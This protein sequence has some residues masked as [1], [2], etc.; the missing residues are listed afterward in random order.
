M[1]LLMQNRGQTAAPAIAADGK[2]MLATAAT[3]LICPQTL[4]SQWQAE[5]ERHSAPPMSV[6]VYT[7]N[8]RGI[9]LRQIAA[10]DVVLVSFEA[11]KGEFWSRKPARKSSRYVCGY[12]A[13]TSGR[14][15]MFRLLSSFG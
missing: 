3:L 6:F 12:V 4:L 5:I 15:L 10:H 7:K 14:G 1:A 2:R 8:S 13:G 11:L 9:A